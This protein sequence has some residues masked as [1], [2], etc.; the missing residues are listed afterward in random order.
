MPTPKKHKLNFSQGEQVRVNVRCEVNKSKIRH[1]KRDGRDVIIVPSYTMP[2]NIVMNGIMYPAE[3]IEKGYMSLE[4]SPAP[5]GHPM[6]DDMFVSARSPLGLNLGYFGA[7]NA[8]V[9]RKDGRVYVEKIIDVARASESEMGRRVMEALEE[10]NPIHTS[11]G[12]LL[13]LRECRNSDVAEYEG[14]DLEFDHD[15]ILLDEQGAATPEQGVGMMVNKAR[16][17]KG[18]KIT[19]IN[20]DVSERFDQMIDYY[21]MELLSAIDRKE[22]ASRWDRIKSAIMEALSLGREEGSQ[23]TEET[24]ADNNKEGFEQL[25]ARVEGI[26]KSVQSIVETVNKMTETVEAASKAVEAMNADRKAKHDLLVNKVVEAELLSEDEAKATPASVLEKMLGNAD[27]KPGPG[28]NG[29]FKTNDSKVSLAE[30]W[31]Q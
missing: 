19:V 20:S 2:D 13:H 24:M 18:N 12:V 17:G 6:V 29:G 3:E 30:E 15:A 7:W 4:N 26:E 9:E 5:L 1:E 22:T 11:T 8:N 27:V 28:I 14:Y 31:E 10:G 23:P 21:G 16:D 25:A